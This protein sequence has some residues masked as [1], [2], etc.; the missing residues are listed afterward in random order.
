MKRSRR[1]LLNVATGSAALLAVSRVASAQAYPTR[2]VS[3]VVGFAPAGS[4]DIVARLMG[5]G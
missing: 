4:N 5:S 3:G 1:E 2:P